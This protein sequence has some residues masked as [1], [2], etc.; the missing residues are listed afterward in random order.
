MGDGPKIKKIQEYLEFVTRDARERNWLI[1]CL[2]FGTFWA[3][4]TQKHP[5]E[6][7]R[8]LF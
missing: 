8:F 6:N 3:W 2:S 5:A 1:V 4:G 7:L